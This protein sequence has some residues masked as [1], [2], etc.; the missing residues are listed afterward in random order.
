MKKEEL[1]RG[2]RL[3]RNLAERFN[4]GECVGIGYQ[5]FCCFLHDV[6]TFKELK[7]RTWKPGDSAWA[8]G[9]AELITDSAGRIL[10]TK[11]GVTIATGMDTY[12]WNEKPPHERPAEAFHPN[13]TMRPPYS[14]QEF[15][16]VFP[17]HSRR[18]ITEDE[19]YFL[20]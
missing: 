10:V 4:K 8:I 13:N 20:L 2:I 15:E 18:L 3:F 5:Q 6:L 11:N 9:L 17:V 12:I 16:R 1:E 7:G 14:R 19:L